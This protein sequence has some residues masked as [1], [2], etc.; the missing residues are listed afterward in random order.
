MAN[1]ETTSK[2]QRII[3]LPVK[4]PLKGL[5]YELAENIDNATWLGETEQKLR[6]EQQKRLGYFPLSRLL[7]M[8]SKPLT[9]EEINFLKFDAKAIVY[10]SG[11]DDVRRHTTETGLIVVSSC[12]TGRGLLLQPNGKLEVSNPYEIWDTFVHGSDNGYKIYATGNYAGRRYYITHVVS[13][14]TKESNI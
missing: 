6:K 9:S 8:I 4:L 5:P 3:E 7:E 12:D 10:R 1:Q 11:A 14:E 2:E 13:N